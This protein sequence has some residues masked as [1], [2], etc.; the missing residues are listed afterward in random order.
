MPGISKVA[1][2]RAHSCYPGQG[3]CADRGARP[4]Q[5]PVRAAYREGFVD[6]DLLEPSGYRTTIEAGDLVL[7]KDGLPVPHDYRT[8]AVGEAGLRLSAARIG[9]LSGPASLLDRE[10]S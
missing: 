4:I 3:Y 5:E 6:P 9:W 7:C 1:Q 2:L 10:P 8:V